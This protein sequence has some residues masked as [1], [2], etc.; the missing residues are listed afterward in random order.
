MASGKQHAIVSACAAPL[1]GAALTAALGLKAGAGAAAGCL[2]GILVGP[3]LD[4]VDN[5]IIHHGERRF[6][7]YVPVLGYLWLALW[8]LYARL[9]PHRHPLSHFPGIGTIGR[10]GWLLFVVRVLG[11]DILTVDHEFLVGVVMGLA[12][13]DTLHWIMDSCPVGGKRCLLAL[14]F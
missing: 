12:I 5:A 6:I 3:D 14:S 8:D 10:V 7:K 11:F 13:S 4:Q 2:G 1:A 9:I